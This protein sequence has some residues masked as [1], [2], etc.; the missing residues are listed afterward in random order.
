MLKCASIWEWNLN[1]SAQHLPI[2]KKEIK[3]EL[4]GHQSP[5]QR[6]VVS[7]GGDHYD[8]V[9]ELLTESGDVDADHVNDLLYGLAGARGK[10]QG[11]IRKE[12]KR[13][14]LKLLFFFQL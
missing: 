3:K 1:Y 2:P 13:L 10:T 5:I 11:R 9:N 7:T 4:P 14:I 8:P 12:A 6:E